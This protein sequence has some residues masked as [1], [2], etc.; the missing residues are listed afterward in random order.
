MKKKLTIYIKEELIGQAKRLAGKEGRSLSDV[1]QD[2]FVS[3]SKYAPA[4]FCSSIT[5]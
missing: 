1:L 3:Y 4:P 5:Q 2:A